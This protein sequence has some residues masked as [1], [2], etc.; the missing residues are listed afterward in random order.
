[1]DDKFVI[2]YCHGGM[3]HTDFMT[4]VLDLLRLD[5]ERKA[6]AGQISVRGLY[7]AHSR[8]EVVDHFLQQD[9]I[10]WLLFVDTD[11]VF[12]PKHA[13]DL[14]DAANAR[15]ADVMAGVY[16]G[17]LSGKLWPVLFAK[18]AAG[19]YGP[20]STISDEGI[21]ELDAVG[22]GFTLIHRRVLEGMRQR[23]EGPWH[24]FD[25]DAYRGQRMGEDICFSYRAT[26]MGFKLHYNGAVQVNHIKQRAESWQ[27]WLDGARGEL[28]ITETKKEAA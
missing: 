1:M 14:L 13:Y 20:V 7:I 25:H 6:F 9:R 24:W 5:H 23:Y 16:F 27:T 10:N 11:I 15:H 28:V 18:N 12:T 19:D 26:A 21:H 2:A 22:M 4:S 3:V 8:N 17:Y